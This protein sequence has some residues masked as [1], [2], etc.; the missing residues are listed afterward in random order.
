[1]EILELKNGSIDVNVIGTYNALKNKLDFVRKRLNC[2]TNPN[3]KCEYF[4]LGD[5]GNSAYENEHYIML[6]D[7]R[8]NLD[9]K[10]KQEI[11][12]FLTT[13]FIEQM[14]EVITQMNNLI[15]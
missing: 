10:L 11:I 5:Y 14:N 7:N 13:K 12:D 2:T 9:D 6:S 8:S 1:M 15:N 4:R 3:F